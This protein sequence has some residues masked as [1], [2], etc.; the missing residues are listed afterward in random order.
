MLTLEDARTTLRNESVRLTPQRL[1]IA[2]VLIGNREHPT[3]ERIHE[4]VLDKYPSISLATVYNTVTLL[5]RY[6]LITLLHGGK[7]GLRLDPV[8]APHAHAH[9]LQCGQVIDVPVYKQASVDDRMLQ[10]F[11][12]ARM[13]ISIFGCCPKCAQLA[14]EESFA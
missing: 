11:Q 9:C 14:R 7:D 2:E 12:Q 6:G 5:A 1:M 8:T 3:V 13:E 4:I 10:G